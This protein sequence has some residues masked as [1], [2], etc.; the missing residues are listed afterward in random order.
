MEHGISAGLKN[1]ISLFEAEI[2][3]LDLCSRSRTVLQLLRCRCFIVKGQLAMGLGLGTFL[4]TSEAAV[5]MYPFLP[6]SG[7]GSFLNN[8]LLYFR[9]VGGIVCLCLFCKKRCQIS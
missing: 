1:E 5:I 6:M 4:D 9:E 8:K 7:A 3:R 2:E